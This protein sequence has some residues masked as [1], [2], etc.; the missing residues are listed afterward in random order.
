MQK[1]LFTIVF[2]LFNAILLFSQSQFIYLRYDPI[3]G[4]SNVVIDKIE[5]IIEKCEVGEKFVIFRSNELQ[6]TIIKNISDW[7]NLKIEISEQQSS[8]LPDFI[9]EIKVLNVLFVEIFDEEVEINSGTKLNGR[10]DENWEITF[11]LSEK[12]YESSDVEYIPL[13]LEAINDLQKRFKIEYLSYDKVSI[14]NVEID[15]NSMFNFK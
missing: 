13:E 11:I 10:Y 7:N 4:T 9:Y 3:N 14:R 8:L 15:N 5:S 2:L 6:P 1:I 12:M